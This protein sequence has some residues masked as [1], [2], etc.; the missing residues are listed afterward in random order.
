MI[1]VPTDLLAGEGSFWFIDRHLHKEPSHDG[2]GEGALRISF[3]RGSIPFVRASPSRPS[4]LPKAPFPNT[5]TLGLG[6]QHMN[7]G[8][9]GANANIQSITSCHIPALIWSSHVLWNFL[10]VP[11]SYLCPLVPAPYSF[12]YL[13]DH[14]RSCDWWYQLLFH[15]YPLCPY[16][17]ILL[18]WI[19]LQLTLHSDASTKEYNQANGVTT[20][21]GHV[22]PDQLVSFSILHL[23]RVLP[24]SKKRSNQFSIP[25]LQTCWD[26]L[27]F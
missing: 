4:H 16:L 26:P 25:H 19:S 18:T 20:N 6:F 13:I 2:R 5:I 27:S 17:L 22:F 11:A 7:F 24:D 21:E 9:V 1:K 3:I 12:P 14:P 8:G 23:T 15:L 10:S